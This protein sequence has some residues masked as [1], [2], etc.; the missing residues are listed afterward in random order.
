LFWY[1]PAPSRSIASLFKA[2]QSLAQRRQQ[3]LNPIQ[4]AQLATVAQLVTV[5]QLAT[6]V[7]LASV[8]K[9]VV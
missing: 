9:P 1:G 2:V 8:F 4:V 7:H 3:L 6:H 5:A